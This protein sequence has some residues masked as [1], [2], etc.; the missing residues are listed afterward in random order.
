MT[1]TR[2]DSGPPAHPPS[3]T[4]V[5]N[6]EPGSSKQDPRRAIRDDEIECLICRQAFRQLT[7]THLRSHGL[8]TTVYK[9]RFGYNTG[10]ALMCRALRRLYVARATRNGLAKR[11]RVNPLLARP[12]LRRRGGIRKIALE[13][14]LT[15]NER[16]MKHRYPRIAAWRAGTSAGA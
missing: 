15:R 7:N 8:T 5:Q 11:I 16:A 4:T 13:E 2:A 14:Y 3:G 6:G 10:R 1:R 9:E 12:E